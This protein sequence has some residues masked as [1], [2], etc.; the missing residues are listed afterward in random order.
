MTPE[1]TETLV[2]VE[3][4]EVRLGGQDVLEGI[5]LTL[6]Q[7][8][9]LTVVGPNGAGKTTLAKLVLGLVK[10]TAGKIT[11][12]PGLA[13]GYVPQRLMPDA[14]LPLTVGRLM[15]LTRHA[16]RPAVLAALGEVGA[17]P[18]IDRQVSQLSGGELQRVL[19][20]RA[21]LRD[22]D[23]LV[24]DEPAQNVDFSGQLDLYA[25]IR[26]IRDDRGCAILLISHDLHV[27]MST[28]DRVLCLN[29]RMCCSGPPETVVADP[30]YQA[31]FGPRASEELA[32]YRHHHGPANDPAA[33]ADVAPPSGSRGRGA[34]SLPE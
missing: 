9:F 34:A 7:G 16:R 1:A 30:G 6:R 33:V 14:T 17:E 26:R 10:P 29:R 24:L 22:P 8:E 20:A 32:I 21:L 13:I 5:D 11:R 2:S 12:R 27:V 4:A 18:L 3:R 15:T 19:M 28:T 25:L 31:L 23:L